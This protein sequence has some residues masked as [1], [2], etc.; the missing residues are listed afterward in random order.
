MITVVSSSVGVVVV[1]VGSG[2]GG[3]V[4]GFFALFGWFPIGTRR[5]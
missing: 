5:Q 1:V 2:S 3:G 4:G